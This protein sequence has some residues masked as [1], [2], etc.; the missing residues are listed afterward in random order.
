MPINLFELRPGVVLTTKTFEISTFP[1]THRG[2]GCFGFT[3]HEK[4]HAPFLVEKAEALG[5]PAGPERGQ[6]VRG[7][8]ITLKDGRV[9]TPDMVL[10][11][12]IAGVKLVVIGDTGRTDNLKEYVAGA[13]TLVI[14]ATFLESEA[15]EAR[16]FGHLTAKQAALLAKETGVKS[17]LLNHVS[18]RYRERDI[19][20]EARS[21]FPD[22]YVV[23]DFD[24]FEVR[25]GQTAYKKTEPI[26]NDET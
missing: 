10:G 21:V 18:R 12:E 26:L 25:R 11:D 13:D 4:S 2:G 24:Q 9:I 1:V 19:I 5:V 15:E 22:S 16:A 14:E 23:R 7:E 17:L 8:S 6:L 3:F 20:D